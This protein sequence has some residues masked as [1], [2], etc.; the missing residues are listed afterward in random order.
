MGE[1]KSLAGRVFQEITGLSNNDSSLGL[2]FGRC[3]KAVLPPA[4]AGRFLGLM[5]IEHC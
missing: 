4:V 1:I 2:G 3:S 5:E